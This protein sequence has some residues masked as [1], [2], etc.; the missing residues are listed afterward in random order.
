MKKIILIILLIINVCSIKAQKESNIQNIVLS[1]PMIDSLES[2][3]DSNICGIWREMKLNCLNNEFAQQED[4]IWR[5]QIKIQ[6]E[7][8]KEIE[9]VFQK[10]VLSHN[11]IVSFYTDSLCY[12]YHGS[13]FIHIPDSSYISDFLHGDHCTIIIEIPTDELDKNQIIISRV[14]HFTKYFYETAKAADYSCMIDV[15]C[16]NGNSWCDQ[17][18]SV[19]IYYFPKNNGKIGQCTGV[20]VNNYN[21]DFTQYFLTARHCTDEVV[22]WSGTKFYFNYQNTFC[23]G[24]DGHKVDDHFRVIGAQLKGYCDASWSDN[25]LLLITQPIPIQYNVYFAGVDTRD[26]DMGDN[27]TC[28]HHSRENP[29]KIASGKI[30]YHAGAKWDIYWDNGMVTNGGSGAPI[31]YNNNKRVIGTLSGGMDYDCNSNLKH[32]WA[33]KLRSCMPYSDGI[34]N[35]LFGNSGLESFEGIDRNRSCQQNLNLTGDFLPPSWYDASLSGGITI[36]AANQIN[37]SDAYFVTNSNYTI[38]AGNK[39]QIL[40]GTT[41]KAGT[42]IKI[43]NCSNLYLCGNTSKGLIFE[44]ENNN[45]NE[46]SDT[47]EDFLSVLNNKSGYCKI[48][49][50]PNNGNFSIDYQL[51]DSEF[52]KLTVY[53]TTGTLSYESDKQESSINLTNA[54][55]GIY[56]IVITLSNKIVTKK[57]IVQ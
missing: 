7:G 51:E 30:K 42:S 12:Q 27:V 2:N 45:N 36:Q 44:N 24:N 43:A 20:L 8:A 6:S 29:K 3:T 9:I 48:Y 19:A 56:Y 25:A 15:N 46:D 21:N 41:I 13:S 5:N 52:M 4:K 47:E 11:A 55:A 34:R 50:N 38:T 22:D 35:A 26:R 39:I 49:P 33:G 31:F 28:I 54:T 37:I 18:R 23:N 10:F 53:N 40:P 17:K 57:I 1:A 16:A 14:Y 32:D